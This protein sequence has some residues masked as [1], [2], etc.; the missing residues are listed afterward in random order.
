MKNFIRYITENIRPPLL[1]FTALFAAATASGQKN[2]P[3]GAQPEYK[4]PAY[5]LHACG[6]YSSSAGKRVQA[7]SVT[8]GGNG[9]TTIITPGADTV[10][11]TARDTIVLLPGFRAE[12]GA[13]FV[14][15]IEPLQESTGNTSDAA[16]ANTLV[17]QSINVT[18]NPFADAFVLT[19]EAKAYSRA[20]ITMYNSSGIKVIQRPGVSLSKGSNNLTLD[21]SKLASGVYMLE[22]SLGG[23]TL[24]KK[25]I[26]SN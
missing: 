19:I 17:N 20:D 13:N 14:A 18:P 25:I 16:T 24:I 23:S 9:C 21:G 22:V 8:Y 1:L 12:A 11:F 3:L 5:T 10:Y 7:I 6:V 15:R 26:K 4:P 2:A